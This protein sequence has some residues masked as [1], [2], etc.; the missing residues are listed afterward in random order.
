MRNETCCLKALDDGVIEDAVSR[1]HLSYARL[2]GTV[3][4]IAVSRDL[5]TSIL[6]VSVD[7]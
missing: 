5:L 2:C 3:N 4:G 6:P 7:G 1:S